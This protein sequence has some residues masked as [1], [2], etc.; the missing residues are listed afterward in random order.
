MIFSK[1]ISSLPFLNIRSLFFAILMLAL[2]PGV[3]DA[4]FS[5]DGTLSDGALGAGTLDFS[6]STTTIAADIYSAATTTVNF[7]TVETSTLNTQY[8]LYVEKVS[9]SDGFFNGLTATIETGGEVK[10][11]G[12]LQTANASSTDDGT[13]EFSFVPNAAAIAIAGDACEI[14]VHVRAWQSEFAT[15]NIGGFQKEETINIVLTA[16]DHLGRTVVLNEV[17]P[18]PEGAD[19]QGGL[20]GEW[21]ELYN[22]ASASVDV[23]NWYVEDEAANRITISAATTFNGQTTLGA[24]GSFSEWAVVF[25]SGSILNNDGDTVHLYDSNGNLRDSYAYGT[26]VNDADSDSNNT[27]G[28]NNAG[29]GGGETS[30]QEGKS[31]AR[32][33]DG[34]DNW[35]DP[36]PTPGS[37]NILDDASA[38]ALGLAPV[39]KEEAVEE[40]TMQI[41]GANPAF[42]IL[43]SSFS[44]LGARV[45]NADGAEVSVLAEGIVDSSTVGEYHIIYTGNA[46]QEFSIVGERIVVVYDE[47]LGKPDVESPEAIHIVRKEVVVEAETD[48][49]KPDGINEE[50]L[51]LV[52]SEDEESTDQVNNENDTVQE[53]DIEGESAQNEEGVVELGEDEELAEIEEGTQEISS[54]ED[55][56]ESKDEEDEEELDEAVENILPVEEVSVSEDPVE[57]N[58][59]DSL[60]VEEGAVEVETS[61]DETAEEV[62]EELEESEDLPEEEGKVQAEK[63]TIVVNVVPEV[64]AGA[65]TVVGEPENNDE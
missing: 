30:G 22:T 19:S 9:C 62:V 63:E 3:A 14:N 57:K 28:G 55:V 34:T 1:N 26:S 24:P 52:K 18:N 7:D 35:I 42:I 25:M 12:L 40:L 44:D 46:G 15:F 36:V 20:Q 17:L 60:E 45:L 6:L 61:E 29:A 39:V 43:D 37:P 54:D 49:V 8:E 27:P 4:F 13:W 31:D 53:E 41:I 2:V 5:E 58:T 64:D 56:E 33:P 65:D 10:Y 32:I 16:A 21:V 50:E 47:E 11:T 51:P 23:T 59:Q 38:L 48:L